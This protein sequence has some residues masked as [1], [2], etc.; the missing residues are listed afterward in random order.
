A[1][2]AKDLVG[3]AARGK[4][5]VEGDGAARER[6]G[7]SRKVAGQGDSARAEQ[8]TTTIC[9]EV[10]SPRLDGTGVASI[11][12]PRFCRISRD[13]TAGGPTRP[14]PRAR[15]ARRRLG[16]LARYFPSTSI[17]VAATPTSAG[18]APTP[19]NRASS[20]SIQCIIGV[21]LPDC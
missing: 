13:A 18:S 9:H 19:A 21:R 2:G 7:A 1:E 12:G 4:G 10:M 15:A 14:A 17:R 5:A 6:L 3:G 20:H 8:E 11:V 16:L